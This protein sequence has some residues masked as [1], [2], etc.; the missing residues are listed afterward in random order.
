MHRKHVLVLCEYRSLNGG[1]R[2][3]LAV[4]GGL[5]AAGY[6]LQVAAPAAGPLAGA[7][8]QQRISVMPLDLHDA[9]GR[10]LDIGL[11]R[12]RIRAAI[13]AAKPD[14]VHAN[15]LS[16]SRLSGPVTAAL[17]VPSMGHLRDIVNV[18]AAAIADLNRH[19]RLLTVSRATRDWYAAAG[20]SETKTHVLYNGVDLTRFRPRPPSGYLHRELGL[21]AE[22][23]FVGTIG[24]VGMRKG[25]HVLLAAAP[26]VAQAFGHAH[27]AIVG[28]RYSQKQEALDYERQLRAKAEAEPLRGRVHFLG[29]REDVDRLLNE[30]TV[31][32]HAARQE[33]LGRVLLEAAAAGTPTVATDV[34]GTSEIFPPGMASALLVPPDDA[35]SLAAAILRLLRGAELRAAVGS[36][37]RQRAEQAFDARRTAEALA[38]HY[39]DLIA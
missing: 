6:E 8:L 38:A 23:C 27:F 32:A 31:L 1:E 17:G 12:H 21:S 36:A 37:A 15:S 26:N 11:C 34:G 13:D 33:P 19:T 29:V 3:L 20:L 30:F 35:E 7:L 22:T 2:S 5:R 14:L 24:Q 25:L 4:T 16:M 28:Q 10:R 18:T 39:C 9:Q